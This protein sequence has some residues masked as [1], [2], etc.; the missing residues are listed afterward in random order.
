MTLWNLFKDI[1]A[2]IFFDRE[3]NRRLPSWKDYL[4]PF[5]VPQL[6]CLCIYRLSRFL[7]LKRIPIL[8]KLF[9]NY[10][11]ILFGADIQP[12]ADIKGP[13]FIGHT[14]GIVIGQN[15]HID[16][17]CVIFQGVTITPGINPGLELTEKDSLFVGRGAK[18]YAGSKIL[19]NLVIGSSA[20][21]GANAVVLTSVPE[22]ATVAGIPARVVGNN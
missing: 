15:V 6:S 8:P 9:R 17:N 14:T 11:I 2:D 3:M 22:G 21:V 12:E 4:R 20:T 18:L 13:C 10:N 1:K 16:R 5:V 19:G 7:H